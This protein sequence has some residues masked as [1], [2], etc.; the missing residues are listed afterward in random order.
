MA[1]VLLSRRVMVSACTPTVT[2]DEKF[3][4]DEEYE[5]FAHAEQLQLSK[6]CV[7]DELRGR[8]A[9]KEVALAA[10]RVPLENWAPFFCQAT[11]MLRLEMSSSSAVILQVRLD[12]TLGDAGEIAM[13]EIRGAVLFM[14]VSGA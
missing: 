4:D 12:E 8:L 2:F 14:F 7:I 5:L 11:V 6:L 9:S 1:S 13:A 3:T 10:G